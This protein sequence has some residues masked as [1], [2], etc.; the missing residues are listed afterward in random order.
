M[1]TNY[2]LHPSLASYHQ[3]ILNPKNSVLIAHRHYPSV[4]SSSVTSFGGGGRHGDHAPV[5]R[6]CTRPQG[7]EYSEYSEF[8][9]FREHNTGQ[10]SEH[11]QRAQL[12]QLVHTVS[13]VTAQ[14]K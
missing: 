8:R 13:T 4:S 5:R 12:V 2:P 1:H 11:G 6:R 10:Y 14:Y 3:P 7:E 9:E